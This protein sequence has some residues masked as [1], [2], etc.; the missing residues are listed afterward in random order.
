MLTYDLSDRGRQPL[1]A[2]LYRHI[3]EDI[4]NG[5]LRA[6]EKLPSKRALAQHLQIS[7]ITVENA[8]AQLHAEGYIRTVQKSGCFVCRVE[9][10]PQPPAPAR[11]AAPP[12]QRVYLMDFTS[13]SICAENFPFSTWAKLMRKTLLEQ[14]TRLLQAAPYNGVACLRKAIADDLYHTR[15]MP[16]SPEQL[17]IGAGTEYLYNL[18]IQ[19]LGRER[20]FAV[21]DPGYGKISKIYQI[22]HVRYRRVPIDRQGLDLQKLEQSGADVVHISPS[23]HYPTGIVTPIGRRQQILHWADQSDS[24]YIIEDDYDS[25]FRFTGR[26]IPTMQSIDKHEKVLYINTFSKSISPAIR[27][28]YLVL[29]KGL[30]QR[31]RRT[32]SF[33]ACTVPVFEQYTLAAFIAEGYF[34]R[35]INRMKNLYRTRRDSVIHAILQ[36]PLKDRVKITE[37]NAG[38]H[39]LLTV[40]T[41]RSDRAIIDAADRAGIRL[42]CLADYAGQPD[43]Q[44][45]HRFVINYSG[46][47]CSRLDEAVRRLSEVVI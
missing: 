21:E 3:R 46:I 30:S 40:D 6:G 22:N 32:M 20:T 34:E 18:I 47:D 39:F 44:F 27:I 15:G 14:N 26:P 35:H 31:F 36:S 28:S 12:A 42:S 37:E 17:V 16:V 41:A 7:V 38:L 9:R 4:L 29:P 23:H 13:N 33:Y 45:A 2:C 8:Y 24:R 43:E 25:E 11:A 1:Y 19:L 10:Q 5:K